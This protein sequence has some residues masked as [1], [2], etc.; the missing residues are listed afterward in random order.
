MLCFVCQKIAG[1]FLSTNGK[2][3]IIKAVE[4]IVQVMVINLGIHLLTAFMSG[5][6]V[7]VRGIIQAMV[8]NNYFVAFYVTLYLI[9]PYIN[10]LLSRLSDK[11]FGIFLGLSVVLF[12]F[13]PTFIDFV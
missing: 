13:W 12:S 1:Y 7:T 11:Q 10:I 9:S 6:G 3:R 4:L 2:R 8:P 5:V